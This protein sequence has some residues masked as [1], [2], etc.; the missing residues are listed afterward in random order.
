MTGG[1][2]AGRAVALEARTTGEDVFTPV[3]TATADA[4]GGLI[5]VVRPEVTT[6][7]R[8][9]YAGAA[10]ARSRFSGEAVVRVRT[11]EHPARR[12]PTTL[13]IRAMKPIV[14]P[15]GRERRPRHASHGEGRGSAVGTSSCWP[16]RRRSNGWQFLRVCAPAATAR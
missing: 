14:A 13:S 2:A 5:L 7:Y 8:W 12:I 4:K 3:G 15:G 10:D 9:H 11:G 16:V 6:R 1:S